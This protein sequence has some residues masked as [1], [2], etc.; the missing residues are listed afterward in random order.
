MPRNPAWLFAAAKGRS[1]CLKSAT[2]RWLARETHWLELRT[3]LRWWGLWGGGWRLHLALANELNSHGSCLVSPLGQACPQND[4][5][6][7][8]ICPQV[9]ALTATG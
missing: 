8:T 7:P 6:G 5:P 2:S 9:A 1:W 3:A 4:P